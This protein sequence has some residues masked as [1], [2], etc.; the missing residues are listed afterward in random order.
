MVNCK[1]WALNSVNPDHAS[2]CANYMF[3]ELSYV[4]L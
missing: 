3:L 4:S 2:E 1:E